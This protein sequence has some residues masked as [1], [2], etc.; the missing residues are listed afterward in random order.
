MPRETE[1]TTREP[2]MELWRILALALVVAAG[3]LF[4]HLVVPAEAEASG[5]A[6]SA[7]TTI[8]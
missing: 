3:M 2:I 8:R 1:T 7:V 4:V 5:E 6:A